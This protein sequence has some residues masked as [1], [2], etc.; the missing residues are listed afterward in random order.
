M[1]SASLNLLLCFCLLAGGLSALAVDQPVQRVD[2]SQ[3]RF[4]LDPGMRVYRDSSGSLTLADILALDEAAFARAAGRRDLHFGYTADHLWLVKTLELDADQVSDWLVELEYPYLDH[5]RLYLEQDGHWSEFRSGLALPVAQRAIQHRQAVFP[6]RLTPQVPVRIVLHVQAAGSMTL[7]ANLWQTLA[8]YEQSD[9]DYVVMSAYYGMLLALG[10]YNLLLFLGTRQAS[11]LLYACFVFSFSAG[12]LTINGIGPLVLWPNL[13]APGSRV[14]PTGF[15][16][17]ATFAFAFAR[18]FLDTRRHAP[19]WDRVLLAGALLCALAVLLSFFI[20]VQRALWIMSSFGLLTTL[21]LLSCGLTCAVRRVPGAVIF[22]LAWSMLLLGTSLLALRNVGLLPSNFV[23]VY[24]IQ[25]GSA[26][27][28][29]LLSLGLAA[30]FNELK[31]QKAEAQ[32]AMVR[33]LRAQEARLEQMVDERTQALAEA[34]ERLA[35]QALTDPLT[36]LLNRAGLAQH[37]EKSLHRAARQQQHLAVM[38]LD[39]DGFKPIN[40]EHGHDAGDEV[41]LAVA[42]RLRQCARGS[43]LI[44][45]LGGDEFVLVAEDVADESGALRVGQRILRQLCLPISLDC[46]V[47]V[48]ISASI[49]VSLTDPSETETMDALIKR[50]DGAMY[51]RKRQGKSGVTLR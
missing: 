26:A 31:R 2:L 10:L 21:V 39:L 28:M 33:A 1:I 6:L 15:L 41:L 30:R 4:A 17:A 25:I 36:G 16:L 12:V 42:E 22:V 24:S 20:P 38:M 32:E 45:R 51:Q 40:D 11:F 9:R 14:L 43:D 8:F 13:G 49:G 48:Q 5:V 19:R 27:E 50:A 35:E 46:G 7:N 29:L 47:R 23:T 34:N 44:A 37:L 18:S 3:T